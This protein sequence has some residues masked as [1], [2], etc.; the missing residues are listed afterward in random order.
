[1]YLEEN[2][3]ITLDIAETITTF[4]LYVSGINSIDFINT[5]THLDYR[6][7]SGTGSLYCPYDFLNN[8]PNLRTLILFYIRFDSFPVFNSTSLTTLYL[9]SLTL[10]NVATILPSMLIAPNLY[11]IDLRQTEVKQW[12]HLIPSSFDNTSISSFYLSGFQHIYSYQF[13]NNPLLMYLYLYKFPTDFTFDENALSGMDALTRL[14]IRNSPTNI[15]FLT[16]YTF[17]ILTQLY[18]SNTETT[19][20]YQTF[21]E[22]Q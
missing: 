14:D 20:L 4:T 9:R 3:T 8:L 22:R 10:P 19:T 15:D 2:G 18:L 13:A 16:N 5:H 21:F 17:P 7:I 11:F 6:F 1:M 12:Y